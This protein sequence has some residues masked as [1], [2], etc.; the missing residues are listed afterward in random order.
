MVD[1][2]I[3][4]LELEHLKIEVNP[5]ASY[6]NTESSVIFST[7]T[8]PCS[9]QIWPPFSW[10]FGQASQGEKITTELTCWKVGDGIFGI[11]CWSLLFF[12]IENMIIN[13]KAF[14]WGV[15]ILRQCQWNGRPRW[16]D[17]QYLFGLRTPCI[18]LYPLVM[19]RDFQ[20]NVLGVIAI[21]KKIDTCFQDGIDM[22]RWW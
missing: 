11:F 13:L 5:P 2:S 20:I 16:S 3:V 21:P 6:G 22:Y 19:D 15:E 7:W 10:R 1:L 9:V 14:F 18:I 8:W 4:M 17:W 12:P